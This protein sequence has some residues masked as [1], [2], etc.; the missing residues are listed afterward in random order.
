MADRNGDGIV[1]HRSDCGE[2]YVRYYGFGGD[3]PCSACDT[4][5]LSPA[6]IKFI[7]QHPDINHRWED[8]FGDLDWKKVREKCGCD[9]CKQNLNDET[10]GD[11]FVMKYGN[12]IA[13]WADKFANF[14]GF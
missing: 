7:H 1:Y 3:G 4:H 12:F 5:A 6:A 13:S 14:F 8:V 2:N 11:S 9:V 10:D